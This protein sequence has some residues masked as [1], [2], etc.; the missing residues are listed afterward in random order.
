MGAAHPR[1]RGDHSW[2]TPNRSTHHGSPPLARGPRSAAAP[3]ST[4]KRLTP[5]RAGTPPRRAHGPD[6]R[7]AHPRSRGDH[8]FTTTYRQPPGGSPPLARGPHDPLGRV[9]LQDRLTPARAGTTLLKGPDDLLRAAHPRS[10][11]DHLIGA[12]PRM[13]KTG[14]PPLARGPH[15]VGLGELG[16]SRL[17]P[18]RAGT[19]PPTGGRCSSLTAHPRSRGDHR[20]RAPGRMGRHGSPPLA[21][22]PPTPS[23]G[24][25][26]TTRLTPARAGTTPVGVVAG[27]VATAHP[28]SRGDHPTP[29]RGSRGRSGSPPLAWGPRLLR[30]RM[31]VAT[32]LTPARAG[33]TPRN[34]GSRCRGP[35]HPRSRGDHRPTAVHPDPTRGSP[36]LA[37]GP[38]GAAGEGGGAALAHPRSRGDHRSRRARPGRWGGSPP[39]ARGPLLGVDPHALGGR[40]TPARAGTTS[41]FASYG[42]YTPAHPRSRGDHPACASSGLGSCGSPPLARGPQCGPVHRRG[43][44]RLTPARAGTTAPRSG[45]RGPGAA[46]P[47][48]RGDHR[49]NRR[50]HRP[51]NGSPP[52]A[53][54]PQRPSRTGPGH[55]RLTPA[56]A[57][58]TRP[59]RRANAS[60]TAHPRSRGD[61]CC[62]SHR[63]WSAS[64][65]P[66][67]ARGP[68]DRRPLA[69]LV[70]R[71]TPARAGTTWA[72]T[73]G[74]GAIT[75]HPRSRGDHMVPI[76]G[77][78][79]GIGSPPLARG[80]GDVAGR[81]ALHPRLTPARAGTTG[82]EDDPV[83]GGAAHPRSR[84]DHHQPSPPPFSAG[85]SPP[86]ARGPRAPVRSWLMPR[87]LT[88][89][90][91]GT[92]CS[93]GPAV[94]S[95]SAHPR[96]RAD[97]RVSRV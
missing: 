97:H 31:I 41:V 46:H 11:G 59:T 85:G 16:D 89:A 30:R 83:H 76:I 94:F 64:G 79:S 28:R 6:G 60:S 87:R 73:I 7:P 65:S 69:V 8:T 18:A 48:S 15:D 57:G 72:R 45:H 52:L 61:H 70:Q 91:A 4:R 35:A 3:A 56:R 29:R 20:P 58:T 92:T 96:S 23:A 67:L 39:L 84:G 71:L 49:M 82:G 78:A 24:S 32:R 21:R 86:L 17:T 50:N 44:V 43:D 53:R 12:K 27:S 10:R 38:R 1:S 22:G 13:G 36:P 9:A 80:P 25:Y 19:T 63:T 5:A 77:P 74:A 75:A 95:G 2:T 68:P 47:R 34:R 62:G 88:P 42:A 37:R 66:P 26:G 81:K 90:R 40:L 14:S 93:P 51:V 54:G 33:T 55:R